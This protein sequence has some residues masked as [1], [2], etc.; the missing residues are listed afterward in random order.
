MKRRHYRNETEIEQA[1]KRAFLQAAWEQRACAV[2][3]DAV[4][5]A[6]DGSK[7]WEAHHVVEKRWLKANFKFL[8]DTR[9]ALRLSPSVHGQHTNRMAVIPLSCLTD[10]NIKYTFEVM[11][12]SAHDYLTRTYDGQDERVEQAGHEVEEERLA[13]LREDKQ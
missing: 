11:G 4:D 6:P 1:N 3:G 13:R 12:Y 7:G 9:N 5:M 8:W 10:E 2:S